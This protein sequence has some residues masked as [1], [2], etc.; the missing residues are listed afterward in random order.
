MVITFDSKSLPTVAEKRS[1]KLERL[2][3]PKG[4]SKALN[5]CRNFCLKNSKVFGALYK[6]RSIEDWILFKNSNVDNHHSVL[7]MKRS[8]P[9]SQNHN[10]I[11]QKKEF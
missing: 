11:K 8:K 5:N 6:S 9:L 1:R 4:Q 7:F 3:Q 2:N 10:S